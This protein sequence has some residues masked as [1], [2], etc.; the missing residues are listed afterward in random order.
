MAEA[1]GSR[2]YQVV[3]ARAAEQEIAVALKAPQPRSCFH[4]R[5]F[6]TDFP[7]LSPQE[8]TATGQT[9]Y[10]PGWRAALAQAF[11]VTE[12]EIVA[13]ESGRAVAP[14]GWRALLIA[15]AQDMA[16][17]SLEAANNLLWRDAAIDETALQPPRFT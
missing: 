1:R 16:L 9:L 7:L 6:D 5:V 14:E 12:A 3:N 10:G 15:L 17:R 11:D 4:L 2:R 8:L 13:V